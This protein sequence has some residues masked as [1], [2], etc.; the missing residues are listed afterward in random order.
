MSSQN[1]R[2]TSIQPEQSSTSQQWHNTGRTDTWNSGTVDFDDGGNSNGKENHWDDGEEANSSEVNQQDLH[3][4]PA[5]FKLSTFPRHLKMMQMRMMNLLFKILY[6]APEISTLRSKLKEI[7]QLKITVVNLITCTSYTTVYKPVENN[8]VCPLT[9]KVYD[10]ILE[11]LLFAVM[12]HHEVTVKAQFK[13]RDKTM[14]LLYYEVGN[15]I[16]FPHVDSSAGF[17]C[18]ESVSKS[19]SLMDL[20]FKVLSQS[21]VS[22][23][24]IKGTGEFERLIKRMGFQPQMVQQIYQNPDAYNFYTKKENMSRP[25][26]F[27][28]RLLRALIQNIF[29][30]ERVTCDTMIRLLPTYKRG[31]LS[32]IPKLKAFNFLK[33]D[34]ASS[35]SITSKTFRRVYSKLAEQF[36][37]V[38]KRNT[39][40]HSFPLG[41]PLKFED[42]LVESEGE[43]D[44]ELENS[45]V[46][47]QI[48]KNP[49]ILPE[50]SLVLYLYQ[51]RYQFLLNKLDHL[52]M[53][54]L[55]C[56]FP[57]NVSSF[58]AQAAR[59]ALDLLAGEPYLRG[60]FASILMIL[61][62][63]SNIT[64]A[65]FEEMLALTVTPDQ[66]TRKDPTGSLG[67]LKSRILAE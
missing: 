33:G 67:S 13:D 14:L 41:E 55:F 54:A 57:G 51:R 29:I 50:E 26:S 36:E 59:D 66:P 45:I 5:E 52:Q 1:K 65:E 62:V 18:N 9:K 11:M 61:R 64:Q 49:N 40:Y 63:N 34:L 23:H 60:A 48:S 39:L 43:L 24:I 28:F 2:H 46:I 20:R 3:A 47:K 15:S 53:S 42:I 32:P 31:M 8:Y 58:A 30:F 17:K 4:E 21:V 12:S 25:E 56:F 35:S 37:K 22:R 7:K 10:N 19:L 38:N 27:Q 44:Y 6:Q 16:T